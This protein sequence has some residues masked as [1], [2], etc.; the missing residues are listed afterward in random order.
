MRGK[1]VLFAVSVAAQSDVT[2]VI[3]DG[4]AGFACHEDRIVKK[5]NEGG[6][7]EVAGVRVGMSLSAFQ[8][9]SVAGKTWA[10]VKDLVKVAPKPWTLVFTA[11]EAKAPPAPEVQAM[12]KVEIDWNTDE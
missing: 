3:E 1:P 12:K 6:A 2:V 4:S 11:A 7:S 5:V 10:Q 8:D 9:E